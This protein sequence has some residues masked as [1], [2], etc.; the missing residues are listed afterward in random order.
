MIAPRVF[1]LFLCVVLAGCGGGS[2][3][4]S[5]SP[6]A[7]QTQSP[8]LALSPN[9]H[10]PAELLALINQAGFPDYA[11][12]G[13]DLLAAGKLQV[14]A[15]PTMPSDFNGYT[16]LLA[17][18]IWIS[19]LMY[20]RYPAERDQACILLHELIHLKTGEA[21]QS[22]PEWAVLDEFQQVMDTLQPRPAADGP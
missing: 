14:V 19:T 13:E 22:G 15:P 5:P 8:S 10:S 20:G 17:G 4:P 6:S 1:P 16:D 18:T 3:S 21:S 9:Y 12:L 2:S 7:S 11:K